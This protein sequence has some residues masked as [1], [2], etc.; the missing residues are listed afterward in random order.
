MNNLI[1]MNRNLLLFCLFLLISCKSVETVNQVLFDNSQL[2]KINIAAKNININKIYDPQFSEPYIDHSLKNP[3]IS[4]LVSWVEDNV[5]ILGL[6][7]IVEVNILDASIK[8]TEAINSS[9]KK[10]EEKNIYNYELYY[11]IEYNLFDDSNYLIATTSVEVF[12]KTTS[13]QFISI[14][15]KENIIDELIYESLID[16]SNE[17]LKLIKE[18]FKDYI[19]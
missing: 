4:R 9:A 12:R 6:E 5:N 1:K 19:L 15:E 11:L 7:N 13:G 17:S 14:L 10:F 16:V 3:P 8:Q 2:E 18:Y